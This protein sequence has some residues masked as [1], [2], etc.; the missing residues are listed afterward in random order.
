MATPDV[1]VR[2]SAEGVQDVLNAFKQIED[3]A[4][5]SG[6]KGADG[7][8]L[9]NDK[10]GKLGEIAEAVGLVELT[11]QI[12]EF[13][14]QTLEAAEAIGKLQQVT[15]GSVETLSA[16]SAAATLADLSQEDLT[17]GLSKFTKTL[18]EVQKGSAPVIDAL[19]RIGLSQKDLAGLSTDQAFVKVST[20][21]SQYADG[22]NKA[23]IAQDLF[24]KSGTKLIPLLNEVGTEGIDKLKDKA[25][26][27]GVLLDQNTV[28]AATR[29]NDAMKELKLAAQGVATQFTIG[30]APALTTALESIVKETTGASNGF[31]KLGELVGFVFKAIAAGAIAVGKIIGSTFGAATENARKSF[32]DLQNSTTFLDKIKNAGKLVFNSSPIGVQVSAVQ[33]RDKALPDDLLKIY[34]DMFIKRADEEK[35]TDEQ[36]ATD[37]KQIAD[38]TDQALLKARQQLNLQR[39]QNDLAFFQAASKAQD[40]AAKADYD[41][42]LISLQQYYD[43][44]RQIAATSAQK[45]LAVL[46]AKRSVT[47]SQATTTPADAVNREKE[48]LAID[49]EIKVKRQ[50]IAAQDSALTAEEFTAKK[51]L[52]DEQIAFEQKYSKA[53]HD[54]HAEALTALDQEIAKET[55]RLQKLGLEPAEI[56]KQVSAYRAVGEANIALQDSIQTT[57][58][59]QSAYDTERGSIENAAAAGTTSKLAAQKELLDLDLQRLPVLIQIAQAEQAAAAAAGD[60]SAVEASQRT[61]DGLKKQQSAAQGAQLSYENL[62]NTA[63]DAFAQNI[64]PN[65][66]QAVEGAKSF[67]EAFRDITVTILQAIAQQIIAFE[68]VAIA[69]SLAGFAGGGAVSTGGSAASSAAVAAAD[70]GYISGPGSAT[71]D[72]IPARLSNG[73][74]VVRAAVVQQ[75]GVMQHLST[76]NRHGTPA[77]RRFSGASVARFANGGAV[78]SAGG[79][80]AQGNNIRIINVVDPALAGDYMNSSAGEKSVLNVLQRNKGAAKQILK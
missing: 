54:A 6:K 67:G 75:P 65:L 31:E 55:I 1:R 62:K 26:D 18:G 36:S 66:I 22:T 57:K 41:K 39:L 73:E 79:Q 4:N 72:S 59:A 9:I 40:A 50:E 2:L 45:E 38:A 42:G 27:L 29:A 8:G 13:V 10:L 77:V 68:A 46:N 19:H 17:S 58:S 30:L 63:V 7:I 35:K 23:T 25:R 52:Q 61:I 16:L 64:I 32:E 49:G 44:R 53:K 71:S 14:A 11:K 69:K 24:G 33:N 56:Q 43:K 70:G 51:A 21:L 47:A 15:G 37:K 78:G 3:Q 76:L 60:Q 28:D 34:S 48:L 20:A 80:P 12:G 5:K 74:F